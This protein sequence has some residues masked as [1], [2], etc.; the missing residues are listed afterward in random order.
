MEAINMDIDK[1]IMNKT[2]TLTFAGGAEN[3]V[4]MEQLGGLENRGFSLDDFKFIQNRIGGEIFKLE[5]QDLDVK[6]RICEGDHPVYGTD[7]CDNEDCIGLDICVEWCKTCPYKQDRKYKFEDAYIYICRDG[8]NKLVDLEK[9]KEEQFN[10]EPDRKAFMKGR[11][12]NKHARGNLCF[13]D[14]GHDADYENKKGTVVEFKDV[15]YTSLLREK[16]HDLLGDKLTEI[17]GENKKLYCEGNYYFDIKKCGIGFHGD[18]ERRI[19]IGIRL[20][21]TIPLHYQW[22]YRSKPI[23]KR[24]KFDLN[25]GDIYFMCKKAVGTDWKRKVFPTLRHAAGSKKYLSI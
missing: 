7:G 20:G 9:L 8:V 6:D 2:I 12:V 10:L 4:G 14:E 24:I 25:D 1:R 13:A 22:F 21:D 16:F 18:S 5:F 15:P 23:G 11:V 3:H 17:L 19:V